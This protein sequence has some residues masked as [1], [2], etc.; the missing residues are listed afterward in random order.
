MAA[1]AGR[2]P[3]P[4]SLRLVEGRGRGRDSGGRVVQQPPGFVRLPPAKPSDLSPDASDLWDQFVGELQRLQLT[5]PLD[6]PALEI[7]CETY[8][9]WKTAKVQRIA[10]GLTSV[11][12]QGR[13]ANALVGIEERAATQFRAFAA[14]F[15][16]TPAAEAKLRPP[17]GGDGAQ[18]DNPFD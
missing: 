2:T 12:S 4:A 5:K 17:E 6:G 3:K 8:A 16:L 7:L 13:G 14:E 1:N 9:R 18:D 11:T 10:E 15:G